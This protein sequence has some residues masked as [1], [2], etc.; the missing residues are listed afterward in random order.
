MEYIRLELH[1]GGE[2]RARIVY[3]NALK[4]SPDPRLQ[5]SWLALER[6][7]GTLDTLIECNKICKVICVDYLL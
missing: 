1:R 2:S 4:N 6:D 5:Y 7:F 3:K